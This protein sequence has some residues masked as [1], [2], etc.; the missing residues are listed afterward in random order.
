MAFQERRK[1]ATTPTSSWR[2]W[3]R[4]PK[5]I[6]RARPPRKRPPAG[7]S[8]GAFAVAEVEGGE[9]FPDLNP[10]TLAYIGRGL[11]RHGE[12]LF[13]I[14]LEA[15]P[16]F[17]FAPP[18]GTSWK[19]KRSDWLP[20]DL[21]GRVRFGNAVGREPGQGDPYQIRHPPDRPV[22]RRGAA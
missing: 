4:A 8:P 5:A 13:L 12:V 22:S 10:N 20:P 17:G 21:D 2:D 14:A 3:W 7:N 18:R 15:T 11:I 19:A 1:N 6:A 16:P 9:R